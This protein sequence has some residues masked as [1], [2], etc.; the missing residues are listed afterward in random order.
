MR[1]ERFCPRGDLWLMAKVQELRAAGNFITRCVGSRG[2]LGGPKEPLDKGAIS[3]PCAA[4]SE[5]IPL[6]YLREVA[7]NAPRSLQRDMFNQSAAAYGGQHVS[8]RQRA[9]TKVGASY[10]GILEVL[11]PYVRPTPQQLINPK[12]PSRSLLVDSRILPKT[13]SVLLQAMLPMRWCR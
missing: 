12:P 6:V 1:C 5:A 8:G 10:A 2:Y 4:L 9:G 7:S 11:S 13:Y 3:S